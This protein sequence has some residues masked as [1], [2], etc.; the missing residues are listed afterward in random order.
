MDAQRYKEFKQ[1][2]L[3]EDPLSWRVFKWKK[4][5]AREAGVPEHKAMDVFLECAAAG[6]LDESWQKTIREFFSEVPK[7]DLWTIVSGRPIMRRGFDAVGFD[8]RQKTYRD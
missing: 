4:L 6:E 1:H 8:W 7:E 3:A 2:Q 5:L